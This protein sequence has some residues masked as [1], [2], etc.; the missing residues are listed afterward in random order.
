MPLIIPDD[1]LQAAGLSERDAL[2]DYLCRLYDAQRI[3]KGL[4]A[5]VLGITRLEFEEE[6]IKRGL[7]VLRYTEEMFEQ[8]L[9]ALEEMRSRRKAEGDARRQ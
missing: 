4:A 8:D 5:R 6:L 1:V 7:P 2:V 3:G 9:R